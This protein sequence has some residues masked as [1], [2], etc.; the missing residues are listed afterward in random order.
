MGTWRIWTALSRGL[1]E[2]TLDVSTELIRLSLRPEASDGL[3]VAL[4]E[5]FGEVPLNP[6]GAE[7]TRG[8]VS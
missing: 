7:Q 8:P 3:A 1:S 5:K 6:L 2:R 4:H